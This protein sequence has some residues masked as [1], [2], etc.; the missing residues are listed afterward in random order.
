MNYKYISLGLATI[1]LTGSAMAQSRSSFLPLEGFSGVQVSLS[2]STLS[3]SLNATPTITYLGVSYQVTD[4][5]GMWALDDNDDLS[6]TGANSSGWNFDSS[7][8]G[9]GGIFGWKTNPNSG[10]EPGQS[11]TF[12]FASLSGKPE[13]FGAHIRVAGTL[14]GGGN[15]AYFV[16]PEPA[17]MTI[18]GI[19]SVMAAVRKRRKK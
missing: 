16:V 7:T 5:F 11:K 19:G 13:T 4:L 6:A 18:L 12:T 3:G 1:I 14:P 2:G 9:S 10:L 15:T 8:S 17:S